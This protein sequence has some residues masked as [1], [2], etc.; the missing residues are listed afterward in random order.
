VA[1]LSFRG[2][3]KHRGV[4]LRA[5]QKAIESGRIQTTADG[6][7][8]TGDGIG[9]QCSGGCLRA[10]FACGHDCHCHD[11]ERDNAQLSLDF[12][13]SLRRLVMAVR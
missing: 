3:S 11:A 7:I 13:T 9:L 6:K 4:S 12:Q 8:D 5:V 1:E 2:Y 10:K